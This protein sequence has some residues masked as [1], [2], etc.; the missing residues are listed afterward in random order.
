LS[1][2]QL[3]LAA[4]LPQHLADEVTVSRAQAAAILGVSTAT[5]DRPHKCGGGPAR[6]QISPRRHGYTVGA[7]RAHQ[8]QI[9]QTAAA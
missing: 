5:L 1:D 7:I 8:R 2:V 3:G 6:M 9:K 4:S